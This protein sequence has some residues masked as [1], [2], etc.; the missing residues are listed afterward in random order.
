M[1][2]TY[3][4]IVFA[5]HEL[6]IPD[7][8]WQVSVSVD[9]FNFND[10]SPFRIFWQLE[11]EEIGQVEKKLIQNH[12]F[13]DLILTY[14]NE[15]L[16]Q[17]HNAVLFCNNGV[18]T[19]ENDISQ[20]Q[21][22]VSFL[23]SNKEMCRGHKLRVATFNRLRDHLNQEY[24][25]PLPIKMHMSPPYL[26]DKRSM[27]VPFQYAISFQ[28]SQQHS[29]FSEILLD[30]FATRTIPIFW[31][32]ANLSE[33]FNMDGVFDLGEVYTASLAETKIKEILASLTPEYYYS[34]KVQAAIEDNYHRSLQYSD[35]IGRLTKAITD[36][37]IPRIGTIHS[38][39]PNVQPK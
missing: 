24:T 29:Y 30:C 22:Q 3:K 8:N 2:Q 20:K 18:W 13:Y 21:Y 11:P 25:P 33:Y 14:N 19:Q 4:P 34:S 36:S 35:R 23:T 7:L 32:C 15:V 17:C 27:L 9:C 37:W 10:A 31:G 28:N 39:Q 1:H 5:N 12:K 6:N 38:G 26:Q 16:S